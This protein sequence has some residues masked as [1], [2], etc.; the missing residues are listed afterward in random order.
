MGLLEDGKLYFDLDGFL[1]EDGFDIEELYF[2]WKI[3]F[4]VYFELIGSL[5]I[6]IGLSWIGIDDDL[7]ALGFFFDDGT[8][9]YISHCL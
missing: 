7:W 3:F 6:E 5:F 4:V 8:I 1:E 9:F 2:F